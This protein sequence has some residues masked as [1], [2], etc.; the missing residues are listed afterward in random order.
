[1]IES[2]YNTSQCSD[3]ISLTKPGSITALINSVNYDKYKYVSVTNDDFVYHTAGWDKILIETLERKKFG[4]AFGNDGTNNKHLP[5]TCIMSAIIPRALGWIQYP[6]LTH[7]CGDMVWQYIG[8]KL[9]C[10]YYHNDVKIEHLHYLFGKAD[11]KDYEK[12]NS[13]EMYLSDN[14]VFEEWLINESERDI[15]RIKIALGL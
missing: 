4:I 2:F 8:K 10:L 15:E 1:M 13:K 14:K 5:S 12:T 9:N 7:L 11:R 3:I 6:R